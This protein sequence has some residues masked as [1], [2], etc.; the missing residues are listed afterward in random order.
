M[1]VQPNGQAAMESIIKQELQ[2]KR[3]EQNLKKSV[4]VLSSFF[5]RREVTHSAVDYGQF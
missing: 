2:D 3:I 5:S 1:V 4:D